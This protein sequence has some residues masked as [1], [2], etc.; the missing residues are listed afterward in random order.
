MATFQVKQG[1]PSFLQGLAIGGAQGIASGLQQ[2]AAKRLENIQRDQE[3]A[4]IAKIFSQ[5]PPEKRGEYLA[6]LPEKERLLG[7]G[8]LAQAFREEQPKAAPVP[9]PTQFEAAQQAQ[10]EQLGITPQ[11]PPMEM[12][13]QQ[14]SPQQLATDALALQAGEP[15]EIKLKQVLDEIKSMGL[16]RPN[17]QQRQEIEGMISN[18]NPQP[19]QGALPPVLPT[20]APTIPQTPPAQAAPKK[21][22]LEGVS[23]AKPLTATEKIAQQKLEFTQKEKRREYKTDLANRARKLE[24]DNKRIEEMKR[25]NEK[26]EI[27]DNAWNAFLDNAG[28]DI[29]ALLSADAEQFQK[30]SLRRLDKLKDTFGARP[31]QWDAQQY[32]KTI[33]TLSN[34]PEGRKRILALDH[35]ENQ[36]E[37]AHIRAEQEIIRKY[38]DIPEDITEM[39]DILANKKLDQL[40]DKYHEELRKPVPAG[41]SQAAVIGGALAGKAIGGGLSLKGAVKGGALGS[42]YGSAVPGVGTVTGGIGGAVLGAL[43]GI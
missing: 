15:T 34:S 9:E 41:S 17:K 8:A 30:L 33:A 27:S 26:G 12:Q 37:L 10:R 29:P 39:T 28:L 13:Q 2:L 31:T 38:G 18:F 25:L 23:V 14:I 4:R 32:L 6:L 42:L 35:Y 3:E 1:Q 36:A 11:G 22:A 24:S 19:I 5:V 43:G 20:E 21:Y 16:P 7:L 40:Y